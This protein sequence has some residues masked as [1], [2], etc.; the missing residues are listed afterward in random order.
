MNY[1]IDYFV[2]KYVKAR[3]QDRFKFEFQKKPHKLMQRCIVDWENI[4]KKSVLHDND[5]KIANDNEIIKIIDWG[6][7]IEELEW[8]TFKNEYPK[9]HSGFIAISKSGNFGFLETHE[10]HPKYSKHY[11]IYE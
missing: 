2:N 7:I 9:S 3:W 8:K 4:F 10:S 5:S 11:Y 1:D 6:D